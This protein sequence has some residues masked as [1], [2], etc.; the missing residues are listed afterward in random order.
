M[1]QPWPAQ[2][3]RAL[4]AITTAIE[5]QNRLIENQSQQL[6]LLRSLLEHHRNFGANTPHRLGPDTTE[7]QSSGDGDSGDD[8]GKEGLGPDI[9]STPVLGRTDKNK[10][11]KQSKRVFYDWFF[12][13]DDDVRSFFPTNDIELPT[14]LGKY[15]RP[16]QFSLGSLLNPPLTGDSSPSWGYCKHIPWLLQVA[17]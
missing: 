4:E 15:F 12:K 13:Y 17:L 2:L 9:E 10:S 7:T 16:K 14:L 11:T 5:N 1:D 6:Q 3:S 8:D